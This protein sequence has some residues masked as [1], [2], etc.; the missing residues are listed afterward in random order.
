LIVEIGDWVVEEAC[1]QLS[2]WA[3]E[4]SS[5][6][7]TV[8]WVNVSAKQFA[9][10]AFPGRVAA[11]LRRFGVPAASLCFE[12][13]ETA[14]VDLH[15]A[16][17]P[18]VMDELKAMGVQLVLDDF[19]TGYSSLNYI[20]R[21]PIAGLKLDR[22]FVSQM[23][24]DDAVLPI[25]EAVAGM[26]RSLGL[27]LVAEGVETQA[28][29]EAVTAY[30]CEKAQGFLFARPMAAAWLAAWN[31]TRSAGVPE[32]GRRCDDGQTISLGAAAEHLGVASST[33]RRWADCGRLASVRTRGGHRRIFA[34]DVRREARRLAPGV[35]LN[36][37]ST[38]GRALPALEAL[39]VSRGEA[40]LEV[41]AQRV[42][43]PG[44]PGWFA[45]SVS[46]PAR[47]AWAQ[48]LSQGCRAGSYGRALQASTDFFGAASLAGV[49][50]LER[51]LFLERLRA[52]L[53]RLL[54]QAGAP[55]EELA[56]TRG[57][58]LAIEHQT[59]GQP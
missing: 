28:Q 44:T 33:I 30:G 57:L 31:D 24:G 26:A 4:G 27:S 56:G 17:V 25:V 53:D 11:N 5:L 2:E 45:S 59:V 19:G 52:G 40:I 50:P 15:S 48:A 12:V 14:L 47:A 34:A 58:I 16:T 6:D 46:A 10:A 36:A 51:H 38:P 9:D 20:R 18:Q 43:G 49:L 7:G 42:Y 32:S 21:M 22:S 55:S 54:R 3:R 39:L 13:T 37:A 41:V 1:R 29:L 35:K 23:G 8:L